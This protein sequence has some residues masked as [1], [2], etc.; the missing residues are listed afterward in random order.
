MLRQWVFLSWQ[1]RE[2]L[3]DVIYANEPSAIDHRLAR[4][5]RTLPCTAVEEQWT[6]GRE[7]LGTELE[8]I[9]GLLIDWL[10]SCLSRLDQKASVCF[11]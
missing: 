11:N 8:Q 6:V 3:D 4:A 5:A 10:I 2:S 7:C 1:D 9:E